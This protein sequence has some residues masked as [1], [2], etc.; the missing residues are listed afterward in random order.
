MLFMPQSNRNISFFENIVELLYVYQIEYN[1]ISAQV[2]LNVFN[3]LE[4]EEHQEKNKKQF[5]RLGILIYYM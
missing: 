1:I 4:N 3:F 5:I 2:K